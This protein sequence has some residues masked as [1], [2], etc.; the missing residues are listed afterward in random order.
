[1][2]GHNA[3]LALREI[4]GPVLVV[5]D[6]GVIVHANEELARL[7][8]LPA[9]SPKG[10]RLA[11]IVREAAD[12]VQ[13]RLRQFAGSGNWIAGSFTFHDA[14]GNG[15]PF[16]CQGKVLQRPREGE[17]RLLVIRRSDS[18]GFSTLTDR[19]TGLQ[20]ASRRRH[21]IEFLLH[22][23]SFAIDHAPDPMLW[24]DPDACLLMVNEQACL[25]LGYTREELLEMRIPD[26]DPD[27]T[28]TE[29]VEHREKIKAS[30]TLCFE[31]RFRRKDGSVFPV[32]ISASYLAFQGR[33]FLFAVTRDISERKQ[34]ERT[35][36]EL[37][38]YDS[39]TGLPNR[40]LLLDR[41]RQAVTGAHRTG[42][43]GALL[44]IDLDN[45]KTLNDAHG[46]ETGDE[47]LRQIARQLELCV[48]EGD[49]I[50]RFGGDEFVVVLGGL[51]KTEADAARTVEM[52]AE[53]MQNALC[54]AY[55]LG[56]L[57]HHGSA[58]IGVTLFGAEPGST[59]NL[60]KQA[61]LAM[62]KSKDSGRNAIRFFDPTLES[63][64]QDRAALEND[65]R[66]A[67][68][69]R[70]FLLHFQP[71]I[72]GDQVTGAE[73]LVRWR[74]PQRGLVSPF[75]FIP[76]AE[77]TGLILPLG[78]QVLETACRQLAL[79]Q[80][81]PDFQGLTLAV[82]V[83]AHQFRQPDFVATVSSILDLCGADPKRL[84]L[85][86][87]ESLLVDKV[88]DVIAKMFALKALGVGFSLD[89]FGTGYSSLAYLKRLPLDQLKIDQ[90]FV[91]DVLTDP[92]DASIAR[93]II[94]LA[95]NLGLGVIAEGVETEAQK[96]FLAAAG[97]H[98]YQGYWFSKPVPVED[99]EVFV[100]SRV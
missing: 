30:G 83:S 33:E 40:T 46:H 34:S 76:L 100:Q 16:P 97:C 29:W 71:Q 64:V 14:K 70:Q 90:S 73:V 78:N 74:H 79:W 23:S 59:E 51:G 18:L 84:K 87:T 28:E 2:I 5:D 38:F 85:E 65:L 24:I 27:C 41:L 42:I 96:Q 31:R 6:S 10:E 36:N 75:Y 67:L 95:Q 94:A 61:E 72:A 57:T 55:Q 4:A 35:I 39:L 19:I 21:G 58:S 98:A 62:Y 47:L 11:D 44:L 89:D 56:T 37:A 45:F 60:L 81:A 66:Q 1:M 8:G 53:K 26:V 86:L 99:F 17:P 54:R 92:N 50:A 7:L 77:E 91:R 22:L 15:L 48:R 13:A 49:T 25:Q 93:T 80:N 63:A 68:A 20:T 88:E 32:E 69:A 43:F 52:L 82:N 12:Q 3:T 9:P